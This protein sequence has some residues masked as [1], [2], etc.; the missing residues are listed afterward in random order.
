MEV[1]PA[2]AAMLANQLNRMCGNA[3]FASF[4]SNA[5]AG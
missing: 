1:M 4:A 2:L 5:E 3:S